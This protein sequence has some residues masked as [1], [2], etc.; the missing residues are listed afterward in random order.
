M[1]ALFISMGLAIFLAW[2][3]YEMRQTYRTLSTVLFTLSGML[4]ALGVIAFFGLV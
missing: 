3:G 2:L 1:R 4:V